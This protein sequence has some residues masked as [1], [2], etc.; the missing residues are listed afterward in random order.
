MQEVSTG[1]RNP[2]IGDFQMAQSI[3][4]VSEI[5]R[6]IIL[7][8]NTLE[9]LYGFNRLE[10]K[11]A[12]SHKRQKSVILHTSPAVAEESKSSILFS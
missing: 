2:F 7:F 1:E 12:K 10:S 4:N 8:V 5:S 6:R 11:T 9:R 3:I